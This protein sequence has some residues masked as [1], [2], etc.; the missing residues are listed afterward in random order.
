MLDFVRQHTR[1]IQIVLLPLIAVGFVAVGIQGYSKFMDDTDTIATVAGQKI[2]QT[3]WD[4]TQRAEADRVRAQMP[5]VDAKVFDTPMFKKRTLDGLVQEQVMLTAADKLHLVVPDSRLARLISSDPQLTPFLT[6]EGQWNKTLL[7]A[8]GRTSQQLESQLRTQ[9]SLQ[10][11]IG[12]ITASAF[13]PAVANQVALE[14]VMQRREVQLARFDAKAYAA[15]IQPTDAELQKYYDDKD[16]AALLTAPEQAD[17]EYVV[18]DLPAVQAGIKVDET[19][20]RNFY[21]QN[22][23]QRYTSPEERRTSHILIKLDPNATSDQRK[24]AR[25]KAESLLAQI[26]KSP[27]SFAELA[28]RHSDD[29][30][31]AANGGDLGFIGRGVMTKP[32]DDAAFALKPGLLS[33][34]VESDFG[35][36]I[37]LITA[38]RGGDVHSFDS[39]RGEIEAEVKK[40]QAQRQYAE[41]AERFTNLVYEQADSLQPVADQLKLTI[42]K[43]NAVTR[44]PSSGATAGLLSNAKF[45]ETLFDQS[46]VT[47]KRNTEAIEIGPNQ[48]VAGR[49]THYSAARKRAFDEVK[50]QMRSAVVAA[51][52]FQMARD[53]A[54]RQLDAW[55]TAPDAA[56]LGAPV[57][58]SRRQ[59]ADLPPALIDAA[60]KAPAD[61]LPGWVVV[62]VP[63]QGSVVL[64]VNKVLSSDMNADQIKLASGEFA[65]LWAAA[66][67]QS[68]FNALKSRYKVAVL[69]AVQAKLDKPTDKGLDAQAR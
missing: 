49:V 58:L 21:E 44:A 67:G 31:S 9:Y 55:K 56:K 51:K 7:E 45:L 27:S 38:V 26:K 19:E 10:Q 28:K 8:R 34:L 37:I 65:Q 22:V 52:A 24:A 48:I 5:N 60:L 18:L 16:H 23:K 13:A 30:G 61:K 11:V 4:A 36:H 17:I 35:Y 53:D 3:Q 54:Q 29:P 33:D 42:Q 57:V 2:T 25:A 68:Y 63:E 6:P 50:A 12:G 32:F 64:K 69:P 1:V 46:N 14:A 40:Q 20:L 47:N 15:S 62:N 66:E 39:V 41:A 43:A 59:A